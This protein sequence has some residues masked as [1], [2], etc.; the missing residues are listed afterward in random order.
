MA[1]HIIAMLAFLAI[2]GFL[3]VETL[4]RL[5]V[6]SPGIMATAMVF[7]MASA[8]WFWEVLSD[9]PRTVI[10]MADLERLPICYHDVVRRHLN[11]AASPVTWQVVLTY[12][13]Y[14]HDKST[15][16]PDYQGY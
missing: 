13:A 15:P 11:R 2:L 5:Q 3:Y 14:L 7:A 12:H 6:F 4:G 1:F 9:L 16:A 10:S 8:A